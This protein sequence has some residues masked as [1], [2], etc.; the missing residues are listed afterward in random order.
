M[1][2]EIPLPKFIFTNA[3][4]KEALEALVILG[5]ES[6]FD[7]IYGADFLGDICKVLY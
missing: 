3:R 5:I 6:Y 4:E 7:K 2:G 1:L